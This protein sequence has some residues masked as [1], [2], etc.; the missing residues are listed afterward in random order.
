MLTCD[1]C[2]GPLPCPDHSTSCS[3]PT[4][5]PTTVA[6]VIQPKTVEYIER[7]RSFAK[8][9]AAAFIE[10]AVT[11]AEAEATLDCVEF[12]IFSKEIGVNP[13]S[14][15]S[16]R[17]LKIANEQ[18]RFLPHLTQLPNA[19]TTLYQLAR[20]EKPKFEALADSGKLTPFITAKEIQEFSNPGAANSN[21]NG[22]TSN[23]VHIPFNSLSPDEKKDLWF[24]LK[25]VVE[26]YGI[27]INVEE[28]LRKELSVLCVKEAA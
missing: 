16:T 15:T 9:T 13:E 28:Q 25:D 8:K 24:S 2:D 5:A 22:K 14:A 11:Y 6:E 3:H 19:Y 12:V 26:S 1:Q 27:K 23:N 10:L 17:L 21:L 4:P 20:L 7:Y 18:G